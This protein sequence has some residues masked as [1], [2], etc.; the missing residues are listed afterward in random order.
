MSKFEILQN[1]KIDKESE[2]ITNTL[3]KNIYLN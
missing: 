1:D 3:N 2:R